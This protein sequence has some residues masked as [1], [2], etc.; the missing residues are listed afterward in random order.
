LCLGKKALEIRD[1][2]GLGELLLELLD[3]VQGGRR[4]KRS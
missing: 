2:L 3:L 4:R 1:P